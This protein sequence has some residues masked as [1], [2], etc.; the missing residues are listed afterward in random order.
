MA[1]RAK[2]IDTRQDIYQTFGLIRL[3]QL[4]YDV[5]G[6]LEKELAE[7]SRRELFESIPMLQ[8]Y[9]HSRAMAE[10]IGTDDALR[11]AEA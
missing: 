1:S 4:I 7:F 6:N 10:G 2:G 11:Q 3:M 5:A 9:A 8:D